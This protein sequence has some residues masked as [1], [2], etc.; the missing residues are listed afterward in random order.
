MQEAD[1]L[2]VII[3]HSLIGDVVWDRRPEQQFD[4][5][6]IKRKTFCGQ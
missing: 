5:E 4:Q 1:D 3:K 2:L 6:W